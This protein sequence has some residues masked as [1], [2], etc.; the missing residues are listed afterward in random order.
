M[1][2]NILW[3]NTISKFIP[4]EEDQVPVAKIQLHNGGGLVDMSYGIFEG[5]LRGYTR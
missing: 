2:N 3:G 4:P 1:V 5:L